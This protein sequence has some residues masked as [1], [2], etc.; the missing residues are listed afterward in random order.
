[1]ERR[2]VKNGIKPVLLWLG[3][4]LLKILTK[5]SLIIYYTS[6]CYY[7]RS[8]EQFAHEDSKTPEVDGSVVASVE[9]NL[10]G[11]IFRGATESPRL[12]AL[13]NNLGESKVHHL[14]VALRVK[15]QVLGLEVP[16]DYSLA[17]QV[18]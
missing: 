5:S 13:R 8:H 2:N 4:S 14:D 11:H 6:I 15:Q 18:I 10:W 7:L 1:M 16:I 9:Y 12:V 17:V 3:E